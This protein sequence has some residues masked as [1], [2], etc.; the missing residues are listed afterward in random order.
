[1]ETLGG[2]EYDAPALPAAEP[3]APDPAK[4]AAVENAIKDLH[5]HL[6][7]RAA[8]HPSLADDFKEVVNIAKSL[9]ARFADSGL[10]ASVVGHVSETEA[11]LVGGLVARLSGGR[12]HLELGYLTQLADTLQIAVLKAL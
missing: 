3:A 2:A 12:A 9:A 11:R 10:G 4:V 5:A 1:M 6:V 7:A 8:Q